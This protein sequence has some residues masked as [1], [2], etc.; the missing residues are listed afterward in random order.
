[1]SPVDAYLNALKGP[2]KAALQKLR[3]QIRSVV[4]RAEECIS[5]RI[6]AFRVN[7]AIA[8]GFMARKDGCSY[9]PFSG[10]TL[11][12]LKKELAG[13]SQTKSSLHFDA[14]EGL[15]LALVRKLVKTRLGEIA[16]RGK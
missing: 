12:A 5:Y 4:P 10:S 9:V 2:R 6:P 13:Y 1:V 3:K 16:K 14:A 11:G 15:P 8:A 7:G